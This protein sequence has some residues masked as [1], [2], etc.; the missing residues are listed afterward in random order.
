M[1]AEE[2]YLK[3]VSERAE[4]SA[5]AELPHEYEVFQRHRGQL[6]NLSGRLTK[7]FGTL[8]VESWA[9]PLTKLIQR[10]ESDR[11]KV[12]VL[13]E[14]KRGKSTF[15]NALVGQ[16]ILPS[17]AVPTTAVINEIRWGETKSAELHFRNPLPSP[18]PEGLAPGALKHIQSA[19]G[20]PVA[21][22]SIPIQDLEDY[23]VI[24]EPEKDQAQSVAETPYEKVI[25]SWPLEICRRGVEIIDSPGLNEDGNRT[26][27]ST[28]YLQNVDAVLFVMSCSALGGSSE[29]RVIDHDLRGGGHQYLFFVCNRFD[30]VRPRERQRL[31]DYAKKKL[32]N[33]TELREDGVFFVSSLDALEGRLNGEKEQVEQSGIVELERELDRFLVQDRSKIKLLQPS[34]ELTVCL[35]ELRN[36]ILPSQRELLEKSLSEIE[37]KYERV[38]PKLDEAERI[39]QQIIKTIDNHR[40]LLVIEIEQGAGIELRRIHKKIPGWVDEM[41]PESQIKMASLKQSEQI[42]DLAREVSG[43]LKTHIEDCLEVWKGETLQPLVESRVETMN[44]DLEGRVDRFYAKI[45]DIQS[46]FAARGAAES[47]EV[48]EASGMQRLFASL[49]GFLIGGVGTMVY[50]ARFGFK[51][52]AANI[53]TQ[54]SVLSALYLFL[55]VTNPWFLALVGLF[56]GLFSSWIKALSLTEKAKKEIGKGVA[57]KLRETTESMARDIAGQV[58]KQFEDFSQAAE[59]GL[60]R[61]IQAI[62]ETVES[63]LRDKRAGESKVAARK[64]LLVKLEAEVNDIDDALKELIFEV[65]QG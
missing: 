7:I 55:G 6:I 40:R 62:R 21:P 60:D 23:V 43:N 24:P 28:E 58:D 30:E 17:Y 25:V 52:L 37:E 19:N 29:L 1:Q 63:V 50:G 36:K 56:V 13:G 10:L 33:R 59:K 18:L 44:F 41:L 8:E 4:G 22:M 47:D 39:K 15:I 64:A 27:I 12:M 14:F 9:G 61:E 45:D 57:D 65:A 2:N 49:S 20:Q 48:S 16:E 42:E 3:N 38:K 54:I 46:A 53:V 11:F 51:G 26:R 32:A 35:S 34:H 5:V 31:I